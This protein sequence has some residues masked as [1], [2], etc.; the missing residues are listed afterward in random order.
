MAKSLLESCCL[1]AFLI[2]VGFLIFNSLHPNYTVTISHRERLHTI[3]FPAVFK[4][5]F[6]HSFNDSMLSAFGFPSVAQYFQGQ[7]RENLSTVG[8]GYQDRLKTWSPRG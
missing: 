8:W 7:M 4:I 5:C 3:E 1:A 6:S 2:Q